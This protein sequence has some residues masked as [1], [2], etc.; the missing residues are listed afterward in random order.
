MDVY[1]I[2]HGKAED[3]SESGF[4]RDRVL[5]KKGRRQS[6]WLA[7]WLIHNGVR[8]DI[9]LASPYA[10]AQQTSEPIWR[11]LGM[12]AQT[13]DRLGAERSL[14]DV[15]DVLHDACGVG[16]V[17]LV[18]HNPNCARLVSA[19]CRGLTAVPGG[20]RTGELAHVRIEGD[21]LIGDG[22]LIERVRMGD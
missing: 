11:C 20:H 22:T 10:R 18:G 3:Q 2:R 9:V 6:E 7:D 4:D 1:V 17:A 21:G 14:S 8:P 15:I 19:L 5:R 12:D 16:G 13:D